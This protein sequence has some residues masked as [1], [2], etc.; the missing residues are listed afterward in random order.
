[1][2]KVKTVRKLKDNANG[3]LQRGKKIYLHVVPIT[4]TFYNRLTHKIK[5]IYKRWVV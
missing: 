5:G 3:V 4:R 1:M 2:Q